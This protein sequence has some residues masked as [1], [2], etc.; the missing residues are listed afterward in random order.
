[1]ENYRYIKNNSNNNSGISSEGKNKI[2]EYYMD[3]KIYAE[4]KKINTRLEKIEKQ[5]EDINYDTNRMENHINFVEKVYD[6]VK[7]PFFRALGWST[8]QNIPRIKE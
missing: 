5:I 3:E 8:I 2:L 1:V 4:L 7:I 6:S